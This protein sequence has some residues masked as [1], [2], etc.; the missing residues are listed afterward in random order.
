METQHNPQLTSAEI[1]S[2]WNSYMNDSMGTC[3]FK[4]FS[5]ITEDQEIKELVDYALQL[6]QEH[7]MTLS[8]L[9]LSEQVAIPEGFTDKDVDL[10]AP[11]LF[12][13]TFI[14]NYIKQM[15]KIALAAY[16]LALSL[17]TRADVID[18]YNQALASTIQLNQ[19]AT[20]IALSKGVFI[21]ATYMPMPK[22]VE[23]VQKP[24]F[25]VDMFGEKRTLFAIEISHLYANVQTNALGKALLMSFAQTTTSTEIRKLMLRERN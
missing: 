7:I 8:S 25:L 9:F 13:N 11:R 4:Y 14:L 6:A 5:S 20:Q 10:H 2:L 16:G 17:A 15:A 22:K 12:S 19:K 1:A 3:T 18:F 21:R 23:Y 24:H